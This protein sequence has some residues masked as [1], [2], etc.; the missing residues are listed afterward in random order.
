MMMMKQREAQ[1]DDM[2][3]PMF[4]FTE[5]DAIESVRAK[6]GNRE[7]K[8]GY[9]PPVDLTAETEAAEKKRVRKRKRKGKQRKIRSLPR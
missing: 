9:K 2:Y 8:G 5:E 4:Y 3:G 7:I 6:I 1:E